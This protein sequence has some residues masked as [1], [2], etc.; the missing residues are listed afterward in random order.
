[1][2]ITRIGVKMKKISFIIIACVLV[3]FFAVGCNAKEDTEAVKSND[4]TAQTSDD[5][6]DSTDIKENVKASADESA[7]NSQK[8]SSD[9]QFDILYNPPAGG[10]PENKGKIVFASDPGGTTQ[11]DYDLFVINPDGSNR[12][13]LTTYGK[14]IN[15][16]VWSPEYSRIAYSASVDS[17]DKIF[18]MTADGK[19]SRQLTVGDKWEDKF[20]TWSPDGKYLAYISYRDN[21]PNLFVMD[22]YGENIKQ[23]TFAEGEDIVHWP[24]W[25]P[26]SDVIAYSLNKA[27]DEIGDRL[28]T[29]KADGTEMT[30]ILP[31]SEVNLGD[32]EPEWSPDGNVL[33]FISNRD[34]RHKYTEIW[35]VDYYKIVHN[36]TVTDETKYEDIGLVQISNLQAGS[37]VFIDHRP[38]LSPDGNKIV[39]YGT[40]QDWN[41][42]GTNLYT[43]NVDGTNLTNITKSINGS[44]W[45]D[46]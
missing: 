3:L 42:I 40:G 33:Y 25:S 1:M 27:G 7:A 14:W 16:P 5:S 28:Y 35:K 26:V 12:V 17:K 11:A 10:S 8:E 23:L 6:K 20:P 38:R 9:P 19:V 46:W 32:S 29:V 30:E 24:S 41:N 44:E 34:N 22:I 43:L 36:M 31:S 18:I 45:P 15:H 2:L 21:V 13:Q 37:G 39:F 4:E